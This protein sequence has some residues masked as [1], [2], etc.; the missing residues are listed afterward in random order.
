[1]PKE[2]TRH[3]RMAV[4]IKNEL[5]QLIPMRLDTREFALITV[6]A[7]DL[8]P[9]MHN[10]RVFVTC[11][12]DNIHEQLIALLNTLSPT[13]RSGL[14]RSIHAR[15]VPELHFIYDQSLARANRI[16]ALLS[17]IKGQNKA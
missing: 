10:A 7:V 8:S 1:M 6:S 4:L 11:L 12:Q 13:L 16:D 3:R 15:T 9:D 5:A 2:Y 17:G 14:A